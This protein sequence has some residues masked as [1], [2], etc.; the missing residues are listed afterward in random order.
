MFSFSSLVYIFFCFKLC[1]GVSKEVFDNSIFL[2][3]IKVKKKSFE[4]CYN[5]VHGR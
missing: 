4:K 5:R 2:Q 3:N 1:Y